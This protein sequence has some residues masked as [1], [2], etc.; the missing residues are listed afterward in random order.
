MKPLLA[1]EKKD[2]PMRTRRPNLKMSE[3]TERDIKKLIQKR[4][5]YHTRKLWEGEEMKAYRRQYY[6]DHYQYYKNKRRSY[7]SK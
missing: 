4:L 5:R 3:R 1:V 2:V 7:Q 6:L